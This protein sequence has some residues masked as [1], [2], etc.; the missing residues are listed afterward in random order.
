M[1]SEKKQRNQKKGQIG[2]NLAAELIPMEHT[3]KQGGKVVTVLKATP[4]AY[5]DNLTQQIETFVDENAK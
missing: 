2:D 1:E 5:V 4:C 3:A